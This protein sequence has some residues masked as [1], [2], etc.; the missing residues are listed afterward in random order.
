MDDYMEACDRL[1]L[2]ARSVVAMYELIRDGDSRDLTMLNEMMT[3]LKAALEPL[4]FV[5]ERDDPDVG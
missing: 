3:A 4:A 2:R 1:V 5:D